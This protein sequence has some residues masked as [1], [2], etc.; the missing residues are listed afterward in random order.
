[1]YLQEILWYRPGEKLLNKNCGVSIYFQNTTDQHINLLDSVALL[2]S[3]VI[4]LE[5][6]MQ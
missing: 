6:A 3:M 5:V 2:D 4:L 1:M